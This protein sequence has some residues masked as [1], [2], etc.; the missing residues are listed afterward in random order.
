[1]IHQILDG[2]KART[3]LSCPTTEARHVTVFA[4]QAV[5]VQCKSWIRHT[6]KQIP[7]SMVIRKVEAPATPK[8]E[9]TE[10]LRSCCQESQSVGILG[11][12]PV[13]SCSSDMFTAAQ[14]FLGLYENGKNV[15]SP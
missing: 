4:S 1:L 9:N 15:Q 8:E 14:V 11:A 10:R 2:H 3:I 12:L 7:G 13:F 5:N 6:Q